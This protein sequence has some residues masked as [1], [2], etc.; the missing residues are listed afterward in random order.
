M[1]HLT[2]LSLIYKEIKVRKSIITLFL[3]YLYYLNFI[4]TLFYLLYT[5]AKAE[6]KYNS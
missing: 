4:F 1:F 2:F 3:N 6:V 5:Y